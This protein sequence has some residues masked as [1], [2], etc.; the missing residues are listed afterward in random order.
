[1]ATFPKTARYKLRFRHGDVGLAPVFL[2]VSLLDTLAA[3][4][5]PWPPII[6]I[7]DGDYYFEWTWQSANDADIEFEVDGG[8]AI[9][10]PEIRYISGTIT[11]RD[12]VV[13]ATGT[14]GGGGG[15]GTGFTVG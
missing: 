5:L 14:G 7:G 9:P 15:G 1:M 12:Y 6:E 13:A 4:P 11:V 10:V 8:A 2:R 3:V